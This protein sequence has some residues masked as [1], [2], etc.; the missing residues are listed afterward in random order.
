[1]DSLDKKDIDEMKAMKNLMDIM[2]AILDS[3]VVY[4]MGKLLP[5]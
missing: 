2:K 5:V 4:F 3:M 1:V